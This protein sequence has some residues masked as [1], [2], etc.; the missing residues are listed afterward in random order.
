MNKVDKLQEIL[1][2]L[3]TDELEELLDIVKEN[4]KVNENLPLKRGRFSM[5][6]I[7]FL[8]EYYPKR[9]GQ[10]CADELRRHFK[11]IWTKADHLGLSFKPVT[12]EP[13]KEERDIF[14]PN[15]I[16]ATPMDTTTQRNNLFLQ[17]KP[18]KKESQ[19]LTKDTMIDKLLS[20]DLIPTSRSKRPSNM[21]SITCSKCGIKIK[22]NGKIVG[23]VERFKCNRCMTKGR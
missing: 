12:L 7:D 3:D 19:E 23:S 13:P 6:E 22:V 4:K 14:R 18:T 8:I 15:K 17:H 5:K 16:Y 11:S 1:S 20:K 9:G 2:K 10:W 21:I